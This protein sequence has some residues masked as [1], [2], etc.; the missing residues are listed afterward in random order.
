MTSTRGGDQKREQGDGARGRLSRRTAI[1]LIVGAVVVVVVVVLLIM[2][3][4]GSG[5]AGGGFGY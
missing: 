4:G 3:M 1:A 5:G 2:S